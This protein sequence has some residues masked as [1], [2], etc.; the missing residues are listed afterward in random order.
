M[1]NGPVLR[2]RQHGLLEVWL[3]LRDVAMSKGQANRAVRCV[4]ES[5]EFVIQ[6]DD[7]LRDQIHKHGVQVAAVHE[8]VGN[9]VA[10]QH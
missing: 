6:P 2:D 5:G 3:C 8:E 1:S 9:A 7:I 10:L 4:V